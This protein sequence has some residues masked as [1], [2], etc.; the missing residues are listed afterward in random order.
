MSK[1]APTA[2]KA[3]NFQRIRE[4]SLKKQGVLA[5]ALLERMKPNYQLFVEVTEFPQAHNLDNLT[6]ALWQ[7]LLVKGAKV[8]LGVLENKFE[9]LTPNEHDFDMYG[10][11]PAIYFCT[12][13]ITYINGL[14]NEDDYD[15]VAIAKISQGSIVHL[16][17]YQA[18]GQELKNEDI[19]ESA[20]MQSDMEFL[21][22]TIDWLEDNS[23]KL[24]NLNQVKQQVFDRIMVEGT[25]NIG[26]ALD[27]E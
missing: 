19:R 17:E 20:L 21:S 25:T 16:L 9:E 4:L 23:L 22:K 2:T 6:D 1:S 27:G 26:I 18:D 7:R 14:D 3:N 10:V 13:V 8:N 12:A 11:Y 15:P 24:N 5:L